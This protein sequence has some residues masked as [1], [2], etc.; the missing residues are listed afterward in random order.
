MTSNPRS[1][2]AAAAAAVALLLGAH[3]VAHAQ[4]KPTPACGMKDLPLVAGHSWTY[5]SFEP[6]SFDGQAS[7]SKKPPIHQPNPAKKVVIE[8]K[9]VET[10][11]DKVTTITLSENVD[12]EVRDTELR[13]TATWLEV[14]PHS[15]F[16]AGEPGGGR[17]L[18]LAGTERQGHTYELRRGSLGG[19]QW[20]EIVQASIERKAS[21]G[22]RATMPNGTLELRRDVTV[23]G[24]ERVTTA[25]GSY[26]ASRLTFEL[27]GRAR[28]E[29]APDKALEIPA[30]AVG[31]LWFVPDLGV[32]QA[33]NVQG[34]F[35]QLTDSS[36]GEAP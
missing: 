15:F 32:V 8:V 23:G 26:T 6:P 7:K 1:W 11:D 17:L 33:Y 24:R 22:T 29:P 14:S 27:S 34:H 28:V 25:S 36:L 12:G 20:T 9:N 16:F 21:E 10:G 2:P 30:G 18:E 31:A 5:E 35:Y 19:P 3:G 13:C 4:R